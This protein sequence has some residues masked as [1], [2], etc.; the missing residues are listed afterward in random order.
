LA[1]RNGGFATTTGTVY[2]QGQVVDR[3][4]PTIA[5][6]IAENPGRFETLPV[7]LGP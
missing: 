2:E 1:L 3:T 4:D 7:V 6:L 5:K